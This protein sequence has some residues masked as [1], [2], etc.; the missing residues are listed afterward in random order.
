MIYCLLLF[1]I[2]IEQIFKGLVPNGVLGLIDFACI[3]L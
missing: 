1:L 3:S 2:Q